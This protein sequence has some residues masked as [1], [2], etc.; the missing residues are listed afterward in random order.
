MLKRLKLKRDAPSSSAIAAAPTV[1]TYSLP[2]TKIG[3]SRLHGADAQSNDSPRSEC[4]LSHILQA[5]A[6]PP[7]PLVAQKCV[8]VPPVA[9]SNSSGSPNQPPGPP[10]T[11]STSTPVSRVRSVSIYG[12]DREAPSASV[13]TSRA[14]VPS[15]ERLSPHRKASYRALVAE[16]YIGDL[17]PFR[18]F[19]TLCDRWVDLSSRTPY[20]YGVWKGHVRK[21]DKQ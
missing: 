14:A 19:C 21:T 20:S 11:L 13:P 18:A 5:M 8:I 12:K 6:P 17:E 1:A 10:P 3:P 7:T 4:N 2:V 9:R 15:L 16:S